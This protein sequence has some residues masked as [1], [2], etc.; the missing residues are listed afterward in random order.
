MRKITHLILTGGGLKGL[1]YMGVIRYLYMTDMIYDI[2]HIY[3]TSIG[4]FISLVI[5]LKIPSAYLEDAF[6]K[7]VNNVNEGSM[8]IDQKSIYN[9]FVNYGLFSVDF[10]ME[11]IREF[12][13]NKYDTCDM[14]FSELAKLTGV[15]IYINTF[16][17]NKGR[18][19]IFSCKNTPNISVIDAVKASMSAPFIIQ[20][21]QI[22]GEYYVDGGLM[23]NDHFMN[24]W[25]DSYR[26]H[27]I[28]I[29]LW[30]TV[31]E[32]LD[33]YP[34]SQKL[35]L[36]KYMARILF[37][38]SYLVMYYY[39]DKYEYSD[40]YYMLKIKNIELKDSFCIQYTS[41]GYRVCISTED[42]KNMIVKGFIYMSEYM[43]A[44][45]CEQAVPKSE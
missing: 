20:P 32:T 25:I 22:D 7:I 26:K 12:I 1:L 35:S 16:S 2:T 19:K 17:V 4:A 31:S 28:M 13:Q 10:M 23:C 40:D 24:H 29:I 9:F 41:K 8:K 34:A 30:R 11:P 38:P 39:V 15:N 6:Y 45:K 42:M 27:L 3:G 18:Q 33:S 5:A 14:T 43:D 44:G 21:T 37:V 36:W